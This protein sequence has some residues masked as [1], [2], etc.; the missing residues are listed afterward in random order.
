MQQFYRQHNGLAHSSYIKQKN[1]FDYDAFGWADFWSNALCPL[2]YE[3]NESTV[4]A[5]FIQRAWAQEN[6]LRN[7]RTMPLEDIAVA[8][9]A[10]FKPDIIW[11]D[12]HGESLVNKIRAV[13]PNTKLR[14]GWSGSAITQT[15]IWQCLD[16]ILSCAP[17]TVAYFRQQGLRAEHLNHGF[18]ARIKARL[19]KQNHPSLDVSFIGSIVRS[20]GFHLI[21]EQILEEITSQ[22]QIRI[23]SPAAEE[24]V[25]DQ[26]KLQTKQIAYTFTQLLMS[27]HTPKFF[28]RRMP[29]IRKFVDINS[30]PANRLNPKLKPFVVPPVYGLI[31]YQALADSA[32]T[33]NIHADSSPD[34]ASNMRLFEATGIGACLL[35]D[36]KKN[37]TELFDLEREVVA[38]KSAD[39]AIEKI[40]WLL[41][42]PDERAAI[43]KAGQTRTLKDHTYSQRAFVLDSI[44]RKNLA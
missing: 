23:F 31:M 20:K 24:S 41:D 26:L 4:N 43:A 5:E 29:I 6:G 18:D 27:L 35:T 22:A 25:Q 9:V 40:R 17:E 14:L 19:K 2:G 34:Y 39:E 1:A 21:R 15:N 36:W 38:Y 8:Q 3:V 7:W 37:L 12:Y 42:H 30:K 44:I 11:F 13:S 16:V 10:Q 28:L 33:L 32:V